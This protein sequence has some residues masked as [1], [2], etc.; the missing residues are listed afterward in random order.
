MIFEPTMIAIAVI[1]MTALHPS[2]VF[3]DAWERAD[4][5]KG[6]RVQQQ[7]KGALEKEG[8]WSAE[9]N[10]APPTA[11]APFVRQRLG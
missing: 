9:A 7:Q 4:F 6:S 5:R 1:A 10:Y 2:F 8:V 3:G 11:P